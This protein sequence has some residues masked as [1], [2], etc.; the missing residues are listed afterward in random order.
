MAAPMRLIA[1]AVALHDPPL[2]PPPWALNPGSRHGSANG[3]ARANGALPPASCFVP[4]MAGYST[5]A[6]QGAHI[7]HP[8]MHAFRVGSLMFW[9]R[10][11]RSVRAEHRVLRLI[12][13]CCESAHK[14]LRVLRT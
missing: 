2:A 6:A 4:D 1:A 3:S 8:C 13:L 14:A 11:I 7:R 12:M 10:G 9:L 5:A